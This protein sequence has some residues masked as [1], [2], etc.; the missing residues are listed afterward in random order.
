MVMPVQPLL[1]TYAPFPFTIECGS[2]DQVWDTKGNAYWDFYGGHCVCLTGHCHPRIVEAIKEQAEKLI[3]YS[4]A[5]ELEIRNRAARALVAFAGEPMSSVFFCNSGAEANENALK[6]A[7]KLTGRTRFAS[8]VGGWHGRTALA[9]S[10][11]DD[12]PIR[13]AYEDLLPEPLRLPFNDL[14]VLDSADLSDIAAVILEP[15]QS[16]AG[17]VE[18]DP[19]WLKRLREKCSGAGGLLI[20]DE[21]QTGF[22]RL[23]APFAKDIYNVMPDMITCAKGIASGIPMGALLMSAS[24]AEAL[25]PGDLGSTFGGGPVACAALLATLEIIREEKLADRALASEEKI[26]DGVRGTVVRLVRGRGLLL[27]LDCDHHAKN[28]KN[29]LLKEHILVGGSHDPT[30]LRL[31]PPLNLSDEAI[32]ALMTAAKDF[33]GAKA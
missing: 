20:F 9:L 29:H 13:D 7:A 28:L 26:R 15:I 23:G 14:E 27:G 30:V 16:M 12:P 22:G 11:T 1:P 3:F 31:L 21:I 8:F 2:G 18:A 25:G 10:V 19:I 33:P 5:G 24:V 6:M 4:T 32:E 17:V